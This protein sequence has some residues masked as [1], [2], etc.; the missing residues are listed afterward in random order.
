L[1]EVVKVGTELSP[2]VGCVRLDEILAGWKSHVLG[3]I[4]RLALGWHFICL[5]IYYGVLR[6]EFANHHGGGCAESYLKISHQLCWFRVSGRRNVTG[7][8]LS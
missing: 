3:I 1:T 2:K 8:L 5:C 6:R 4:V 7:L